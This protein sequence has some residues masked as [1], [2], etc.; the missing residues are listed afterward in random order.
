[1]QD[2]IEEG[3]NNLMD[4][5]TLQFQKEKED[6]IQGH[7]KIL[8]EV[9]HQLENI[10]VKFEGIIAKKDSIEDQPQRIDDANVY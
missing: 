3:H 6:K 2:R 10:K 5:I 8:E 7:Y 1:M 9:E 4:G